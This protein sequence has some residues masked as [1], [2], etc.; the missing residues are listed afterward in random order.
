ML[1]ALRRGDTLVSQGPNGTGEAFKQPIDQ[2]IAESFVTTSN[3]TYFAK[4]GRTRTSI[5]DAVPALI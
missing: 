4:G 1:L 3:F 2:T 5:G